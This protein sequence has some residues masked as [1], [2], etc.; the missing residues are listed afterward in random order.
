MTIRNNVAISLLAGALCT[1]VY[2]GT[3]EARGTQRAKNADEPKNRPLSEPEIIGVTVV[4]N[5]GEVAQAILAEK[6]ARTHIAR[7]FAGLMVGDH[8]DANQKMEALAKELGITPEDSPLS[9]DMRSAADAVQRKLNQ[10]AHAYFDRVYLESQIDE[11]QKVLKA[12]DER[13]IPAAKSPRL[14]SM[15]GEAR[16][17]VAHHLQVAKET[18][19]ELD[20]EGKE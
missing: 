16:T 18:L 9:A 6:K 5:N 17:H 15:L 13:L 7:S 2:S 10:A 20:K 4:V 11:H 8:D 3:G 14:K 12:F 19:V 1:A